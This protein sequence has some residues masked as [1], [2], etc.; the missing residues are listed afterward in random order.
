MKK[1]KWCGKGSEGMLVSVCEECLCK[2]Y[3]ESIMDL[4]S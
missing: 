4:V 2:R 1:C 3:K